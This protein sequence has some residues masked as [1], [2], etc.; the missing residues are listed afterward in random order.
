MAAVEGVRI[1]GDDGP[2]R[3]K[4]R[5]SELPT[6]SAKQSEVGGLVH[7]FKRK[8]EFDSLRKQVYAQFEAGV[9]LTSHINEICSDISR[10]R[11]TIYYNLYRHLQMRKSSGIP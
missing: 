1:G 2:I 8:G 3:K 5:I 4:P 11:R 10:T 6:S 7:V 9:R